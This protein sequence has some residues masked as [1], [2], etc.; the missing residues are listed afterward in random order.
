MGPFCLRGLG[1]QLG[2]S[3]SRGEAAF[4]SHGQLLERELIIQKQTF[5]IQN[6][7]KMTGR[8]FMGLNVPLSNFSLDSSQ[9]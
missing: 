9:L 7:N 6:Y 3:R 4:T 1:T 5:F 8:L 2:A